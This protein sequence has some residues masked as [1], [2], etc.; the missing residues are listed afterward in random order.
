MKKLKLK[1]DDLGVESFQVGGEKQ[2]EG[3]V[4]AHVGNPQE[5][6]DS[7]ATVCTCDTHTSWF[8]LGC[9]DA[10]YPKWC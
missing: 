5:Y 1:L 10:T 3:T 9:D 8:T 2:V 6:E 7:E 4:R